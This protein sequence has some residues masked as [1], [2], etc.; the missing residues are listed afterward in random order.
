MDTPFPKLKLHPHPTN[1]LPWAIP[2]R[3][4]KVPRVLVGETLGPSPWEWVQKRG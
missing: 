2:E 4:A 3:T 1:R